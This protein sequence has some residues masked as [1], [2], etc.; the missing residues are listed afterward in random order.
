MKI[1]F[2]E[3]FT[4]AGTVEPQYFPREVA[5]GPLPSRK[6]ITSPTQLLDDS[7]LKSGKEI[8]MRVPGA[9]RK[10]WRQLRSIG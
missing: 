5:M 2:P 4:W 10:T 3:D 8:V 9:D 7:R 6:A 1:T